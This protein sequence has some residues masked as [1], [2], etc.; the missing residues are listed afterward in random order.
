MLRLFVL[1]LA[2]KPLPSV[3]SRSPWRPMRF[4]ITV[5]AASLLTY[6]VAAHADTFNFSFNLPGTTDLGFA[7]GLSDS[8]VITATANGDGSFTAT[9]LTGPGLVALL[10][11]G[12]FGFNDNLL[13]PNQ[14]GKLDFNGIALTDTMGDTVGLLFDN[15]SDVYLGVV[16]L[17]RGNAVLEQTSFSLSPVSVT[18]EP[19]SIALLS[20]GLVG[21]AG[22][23]RR[24]RLL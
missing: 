15:V 12:Q 19:S 2:H 9:S 8:G 3:L 6:S 20:T 18:P 17:A 16:Q 5:L 10:P 21:L 22:F 14:T 11:P 13:F 23:Y 1:L 7:N 24:R 4:S